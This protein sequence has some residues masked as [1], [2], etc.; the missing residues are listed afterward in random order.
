MHAHV[1]RLKKARR[2]LALGGV[3]PTIDQLAAELDLTTDRVRELDRWDLSPVSLDAP[4]AEEA[5]ALMADVLMDESA[6]TPE[7]T[8]VLAD[9]V[10][11]LDRLLGQLD[12]RSAEVLRARYGLTDEASLKEL[13]RRLGVTPRDVEEI[14]TTALRRL[15]VLAQ[16]ADLGPSLAA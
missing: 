2:E 11:V 7:Q 14:E 12:P 3:E 15:R 1:N 8:A 4:L 5:E 13:A 6:L 10:A 16:A 9:Q